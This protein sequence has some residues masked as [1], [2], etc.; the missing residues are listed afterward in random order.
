MKW[1]KIGT[2]KIIKIH[3]SIHICCKLTYNI[4]NVANVTGN[5]NIFLSDLSILIHRPI[6]IW[7]IIFFVYQYGWYKEFIS[8]F[9]D[10]LF[11]KT[12]KTDDFVTEYCQNRHLRSKSSQQS[13]QLIFQL[14]HMGDRVTCIGFFNENIARFWWFSR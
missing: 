7:V 5:K 13:Q 11:Q 12:P 4:C 14:I 3:I 2:S 1:R 10:T 8:L 9:W 6:D